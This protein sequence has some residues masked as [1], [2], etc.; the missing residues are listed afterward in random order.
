MSRV[1]AMPT[2]PG[3][4]LRYHDKRFGC[5]LGD[6]ACE[7]DTRVSSLHGLVWAAGKILQVRL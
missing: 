2:L 5:L 4:N 1:P 7:V 3:A 6:R